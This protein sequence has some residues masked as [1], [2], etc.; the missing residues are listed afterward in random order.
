MQ[1]YR[2]LA[3][4]VYGQRGAD[5]SVRA[6][7][8]EVASGFPERISRALNRPP[9]GVK[10]VLTPIFGADIIVQFVS[11]AHQDTLRKV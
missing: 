5:A 4:R 10:G 7:N 2:V 11:F 3:E 8:A 6:Q 1:K 9:N